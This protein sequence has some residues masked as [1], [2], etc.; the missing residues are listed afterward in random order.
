MVW[1][2]FISLVGLFEKRKA[3][4]CAC[5]VE[6][7]EIDTDMP[8]AIVFLHQYHIRYPF[9]ILEFPNKLYLE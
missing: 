4:F 8:L 6:V 5:L 7:G 9:E 2:D 3:I 1:V